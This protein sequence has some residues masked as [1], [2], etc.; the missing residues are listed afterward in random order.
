VWYAV[1][2]FLN[3]AEFEP[4]L[5]VDVGGFNNVE[6]A[7]TFDGTYY[8]FEFRKALDSGDA[9]GHD[10]SAAPG[11]IRIVSFGIADD[12]GAYG[13]GPLS[14]HLGSPPT[15]VGGVLL[16][17]NK[18]AVLAPYLALL[19]LVSAATLVAVAPWKKR[20]S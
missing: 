11:Q 12:V 14:L 6:G 1:D 5:D 8:W 16:P 4:I 3:E 17:V 10:W 15:S 19:G 2:A 20:E 13:F 18:L 7:P 9:A